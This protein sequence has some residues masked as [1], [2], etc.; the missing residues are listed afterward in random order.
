M[1]FAKMMMLSDEVIHGGGFTLDSTSDGVKLEIRRKVGGSGKITCYIY[2]VSDA[3][4]EIMNSGL[5]SIKY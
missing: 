1:Q 4:V 5:V 3:L 2:V